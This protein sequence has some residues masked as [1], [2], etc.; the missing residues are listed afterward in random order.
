MAQ[1]HENIIALRRS[2]G[3]TQKTMAD[4]LNI[5]ESTYNRLEN[6]E[7]DLAYQRHLV[8]IAA[9]FDLEVVELFIYKNDN[10]IH[11]KDWQ[12]MREAFEKI[13]GYLDF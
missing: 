13:K 5:S 12:K 8:P 9:V 7:I 1:I 6:G 3:L 10:Y 4:R 2:K 11:I